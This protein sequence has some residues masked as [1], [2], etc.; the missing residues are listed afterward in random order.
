MAGVATGPQL[1][2]YAVHM[3]QHHAH[4]CEFWMPNHE[5]DLVAYNTGPHGCWSGRIPKDNRW[6][7]IKKEDAKLISLVMRSL[8]YI[9]GSCRYT[10]GMLQAYSMNVKRSSRLVFGSWHTYQ[11]IVLDI[12]F[13]RSTT[14][15]RPDVME[16]VNLS[17][18]FGREDFG[19]RKVVYTHLAILRT[20]KTALNMMS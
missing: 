12:M 14:K 9:G 17:L 1:S 16:I 6:V 19:G 7:S 18:L 20:V 8:I 10:Q 2:C 5:R 3:Q 4:P 13:P 15:H 11:G